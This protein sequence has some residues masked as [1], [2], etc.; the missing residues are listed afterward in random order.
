M[1]WNLNLHQR[2]SVT[3]NDNISCVIILLKWPEHTLQIR[4]H[5][6]Y[7]E[8]Q[9]EP[10]ENGKVKCEFQ[11]TNSNPGVTSSNPRIANSNP[12]IAISDPWVTSFNPRV[13]RQKAQVGRLKA[14]VVRLKVQFRRLKA[15]VQAIKP[16][17]R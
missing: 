5:R 9:I 16:R 14:W 11:V 1:V 10:L 2:C 7:I 8:R 3:N 12:Q 15:R 6:D 13:R 17:V 4:S